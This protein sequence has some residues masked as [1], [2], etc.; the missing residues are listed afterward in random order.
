MQVI[1]TN[2]QQTIAQK[3]TEIADLMQVLEEKDREIATLGNRVNTLGSQLSQ[4]NTDLQEAEMNQ[5]FNMG[6]ELMEA[7]E[8]LPD[9]KGHGNMKGV[10]KAKLLILQR[11]VV[12]YERSYLLGNQKAKDKKQVAEKT[13]RT[14]KDR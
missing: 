1:I 2:L 8:L 9:V 12:C 14:V 4:A 7:A 5:W 11:A 3:E 10:K 13:Y 6:N